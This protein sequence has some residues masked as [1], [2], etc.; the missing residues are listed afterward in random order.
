MKH[1]DLR[2]TLLRLFILFLCLSAGLAIIAVLGGGFGQVQLKIILSTLAIAAA[3]ICGMSCAAY[4][5][6]RGQNPA[7]LAGIISAVAAAVM[8]IAGIWGEAN[9]EV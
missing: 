1:S 6:R 8:V 5:Q 4:M 2:R 7:G 3:N 9:S